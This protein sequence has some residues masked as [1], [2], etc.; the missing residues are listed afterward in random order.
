ME[1][2]SKFNLEKSLAQWKNSL[3]QDDSLTEDTI[4]E[5]ES[6]LLEETDELRAKGLDEEEAFFVARK[7]LGDTGI[8]IQEFEKV[9]DNVLSFNR[10]RFLVLGILFSW[11]LTHFAQT[12]F[13]IS[14]IISFQLFHTF[15]S[16]TVAVTIALG[17]IGV[18]SLIYYRLFR[19]NK[20]KTLGI[21]GNIP[22]L[23]AVMILSRV[24]IAFFTQHSSLNFSIYGRAMKGA[25]YF[26]MGLIILTIIVGFFIHFKAKKRKTIAS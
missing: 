20:I 16:I 6:H 8:L 21:L 3:Y 1:S 5:L 4:A 15:E 24:F 19:L 17:V 12:I 23:I 26:S 9:D 10:I 13:L 2:T 18:I 14:G 22:F 25:S 7:R 11:F